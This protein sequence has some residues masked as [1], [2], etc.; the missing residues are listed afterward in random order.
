MKRCILLI[1][2]ICAFSAKAQQPRMEIVQQYM[3]QTG[4]VVLPEISDTLFCNILSE[5]RLFSQNLLQNFP[6]VQDRGMKELI[7]FGYRLTDRTEL[8]LVRSNSIVTTSE[9]VPLYNRSMFSSVEYL[10]CDSTVW[11]VRLQSGKT[12]N[13]QL[14]VSQ[15]KSYFEKTDFDSDTLTVFSDSDYLVR[16]GTKSVEAQSLYHTPDMTV[17]FRGV[18][19]HVFG[20]K[21]PVFEEDI[22]LNVDF[23]VQET[24]ENNLQLAFQCSAFTVNGE[25]EKV[26]KISFK[27]ET[28]HYDYYV[29]SEKRVFLM[30]DAVKRLTEY[31]PVSVSATMQNGRRLEYRMPYY[32]YRSLLKAYEYFCWNV[33]NYKTKYKKW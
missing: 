26:E 17:S 2:W 13:R 4:A 25:Y 19:L 29:D 24:K 21:T 20:C 3:E 1:I 14:F 7:P 9:K 33:T 22:C 12:W 16:V 27:N 6:E 10:L 8:K 32:Q 15:L 11:G 23:Y 28:G 30:P 31:G 5:E 18:D